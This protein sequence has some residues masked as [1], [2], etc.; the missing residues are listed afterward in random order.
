MKKYLLLLICCFGIAR[1]SRAQELFP[2]AE[3][4]SNIPKGVLGLRLPNMFF[5]EYGRFRSWN[6]ATL[7][8]G[9]SGRLEMDLSASA[10][11]HHSALLP[12]GFVSTDGTVKHTHGIQK[13]LY[14]PYRFDG[15]DLYAKYKFLNHDHAGTHFRMAAYAELSTD[16]VAHDEAEPILFG[17]NAGLG[18]GLV[19]TR[20][21]HKLAIS[22]TGGGILPYYYEEHNTAGDLKLYYGKALNYSLSFGYLL[23][24]FHYKNYKQTNLNLYAEFV[25]KTYGAMRAKLNGETLVIASGTN[26]AFLEAGS[27]VEFRPAIQLIVLSNTRIDFSMALPLPDGYGGDLLGKSYTRIY[28]VYF[29]TLQHYF[30]LK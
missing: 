13:G 9:V 19:A 11:N 15:V 21:I 24:P 3:P 8:Y 10:S 18:A 25:G 27:Y 22:V 29:F 17:D 5:N 23:L 16:R 28:P 14:Y 2:N 6:G 30:F 12:A 1:I 26:S 4:A 7:R 20:L